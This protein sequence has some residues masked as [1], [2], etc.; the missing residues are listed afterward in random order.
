MLMHGFFCCVLGLLFFRCIKVMDRYLITKSL[1]NV[2]ER[3]LT[4]LRIKEE[5][6]DPETGWRNNQ[7]N[8][9][10]PAYRIKSAFC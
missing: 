6:E 9:E 4:G 10:L 5:K 2:F 1:T 3:L 8:E 7:N